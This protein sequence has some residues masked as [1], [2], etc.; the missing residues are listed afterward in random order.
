MFRNLP[1]QATYAE[2]RLRISDLNMLSQTRMEMVL[3]L[4]QF[5]VCVSVCLSH[6][7]QTTV[8]LYT[9]FWQLLQKHSYNKS[10]LT[11]RFEVLLDSCV[12]IK[13]I[14]NNNS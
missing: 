10:N 5:G 8:E 12:N 7:T 3:S 6:K 11:L 9:L 2:L 13:A 1:K 4:Q 14:C